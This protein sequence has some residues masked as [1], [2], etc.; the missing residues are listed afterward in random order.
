MD[1]LKRKKEK[2][3]INLSWGSWEGN[4]ESEEGGRK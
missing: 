4:A 3:W 2:W 1:A